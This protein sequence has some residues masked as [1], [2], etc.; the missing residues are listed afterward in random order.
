MCVVY[1]HFWCLGGEKSHIPYFKTKTPGKKGYFKRGLEDEG[2][3]GPF[4]FQANQRISS[5]IQEKA[6]GPLAILVKK[7]ERPRPFENPSDF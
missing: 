2:V 3:E 4:I 1:I 5:D 7:S 6:D